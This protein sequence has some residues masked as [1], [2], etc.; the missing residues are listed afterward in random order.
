MNLVIYLCTDTQMFNLTNIVKF[1][2]Q[3]RLEQKPPPTGFINELAR[4]CNCSR[5]TVRTAIYN[6][7]LGEK[8]EM[9]RKMYRTKYI[10]KSKDVVQTDK[11]NIKTVTTILNLPE[12]ASEKEIFV[13]VK[14]LDDEIKALRDE[15]DSREQSLKA[16]QK[17]EL[18]I[19]PSEEF[20]DERLKGDEIR[21]ARTELAN[22]LQADHSEDYYSIYG[23]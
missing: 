20:K 3:I 18:Q 2:K 15:K 11:V 17:A 12:G 5:Q 7:A 16:N 14:A 6:D 4:L 8:A 23:F 13:A 9:V 1:M 10:N 21:R 19:H 22:L